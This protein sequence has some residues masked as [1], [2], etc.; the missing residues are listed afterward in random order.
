MYPSVG[1]ILQ[2]ARSNRGGTIAEASRVTKIPRRYLEALEQENYEILP[3]PVY[4]RGFLRS[5]AGYL[6]LEPGKLMP[7]FPVGHVDQPKLEPLPK[8]SDR[9]GSSL[10]G[11]M[12]IPAAIVIAAVTVVAIY[13]FAQESGESA[14]GSA[15]VA[16]E[17]GESALGSAS[18]NSSVSEPATVGLAGIGAEVVVANLVGQSAETAVAALE[19]QGAGY[20]VIAVQS[21]GQAGYVVQQIPAL[22]QF[23]F[24]A[25]WLPCSSVGS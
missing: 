12:A 9:R 6:G 24:L 16:Q 15:S 13:A 5:Y 1:E 21:E 11:K 19:S 25:S 8:L 23:C 2:R 14:L 17:S 18:V 10:L 7:F 20:V 3:A 4:T 22:R